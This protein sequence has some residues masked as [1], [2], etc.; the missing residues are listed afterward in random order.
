MES[1]L[2]IFSVIFL[3]ITAIVC[4]WGTL[5]S[6]FNDSLGQRIFMGI[7]CIGALGRAENIWETHIVLWEWFVIHFGMGGFAIATAFKVWQARKVTRK[8]LHYGE[9]MYHK[10]LR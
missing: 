1:N 5:S 3:V 4:R 8:E 2:W 10:G 6:A 9:T 7:I